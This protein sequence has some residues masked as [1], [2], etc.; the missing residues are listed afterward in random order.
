M[1]TTIH[2]ALKGIVAVLVIMTLLGCAAP[3]A[4]AP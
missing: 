2:L 1:K 3:Q 4:A